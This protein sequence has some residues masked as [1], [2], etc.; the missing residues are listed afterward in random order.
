MAWDGS[1]MARR[2]VPDRALEAVLKRLR[3]SREEFQEELA[4]RSGPQQWR[5]RSV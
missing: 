4:Y 1:G 5:L 3:T 2:L